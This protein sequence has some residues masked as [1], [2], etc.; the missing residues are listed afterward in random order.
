MR[1]TIDAKNDIG[2]GEVIIVDDGFGSE[3]NLYRAISLFITALAAAGYSMKELCGLQEK[4]EEWLSCGD[5]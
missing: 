1:I 3:T 5:E 4:F 2:K